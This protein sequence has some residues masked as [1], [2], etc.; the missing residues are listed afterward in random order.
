LIP[1][2]LAA[3]PVCDP[4]MVSEQLSGPDEA[5]EKLSAI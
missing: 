1:V 3:I 2:L 5:A 4:E